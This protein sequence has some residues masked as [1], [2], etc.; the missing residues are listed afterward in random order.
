MGTLRQLMYPKEFR[1]ESKRSIAQIRE[2]LKQ[3]ALTEQSGRTESENPHA[4]AALPTSADISDAALSDLGTSLWR[5]RD[6]MINRE[7]GMPAEGNRR[8]FR[9]L[10]SAWDVLGQVGVRI[11]DHTNEIVPEG[12]IYSL[13]AVAYEPTSGLLRETVIETVKPTIYFQDRMIQMGEVI[14]G[15]PVTSGLSE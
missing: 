12:G 8:T 13:K 1:I 11:L 9:H 14:I 6:R 3:F 2:L 15:T 7:T 10:Q 4:R 5:I